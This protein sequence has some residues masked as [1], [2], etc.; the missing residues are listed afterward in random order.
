VNGWENFAMAQVGASAA[1]AGL[2]FVG[3]SVNLERV[4]AEPSAPPRVAE[5]LIG[6]L[7]LL[8]TATALLLPAQAHWLIGAELLLLGATA[9]VA[10]TLLQRRAALV[11]ATNHPQPLTGRERALTTTL[12]FLG[13]LASLSY[14]FAGA[15][16][17]LGNDWGIYF[18]A[19]GAVG[20]FGLAFLDA[21]TLLIEIHRFGT[22]R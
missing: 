19:L 14:A 18:V 17:L 3:V 15:V 21:W 4:L 6:L 22:D 9:W 11:Y 7:A 2:V 8:L 12:I 20:S 5:A 13:Q 10:I 16:L 1:L